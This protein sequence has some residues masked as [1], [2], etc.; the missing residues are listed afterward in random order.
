MSQEAPFHLLPVEASGFKDMKLSPKDDIS[1]V[2]KSIREGLKMKDSFLS[3]DMDLMLPPK[4]HGK[5]TWF[6]IH[7][8]LVCPVHCFP[9]DQEGVQRNVIGKRY[10]LKGCQLA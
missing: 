8:D 10:S 7:L 3:L 5:A 1:R 2:P 6:D 9:P 4:F